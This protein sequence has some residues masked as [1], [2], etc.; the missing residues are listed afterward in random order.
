[1]AFY[2]SLVSSQWRLWI[3]SL[4]AVYVRQ[5]NIIW[6]MYILLYRI[7]TDYA[8]SIS[9][10]RGNVLQS[11]FG[12]VKL[13]FINKF[14]IV[15]NNSLQLSIFPIFVGYLY[16]YNN[17]KLTFGDHDNHT[18]TFHPTQILYLSVFIIVN[19]PLTL[20]DYFLTFR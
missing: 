13:M 2:Y 1:M 19:M 17:G 8:V 3:V 4:L 12:F 20:G 18:F 5:N 11:M 10:I 15:R 7:F 9:S 16:Y 14:N 6:I